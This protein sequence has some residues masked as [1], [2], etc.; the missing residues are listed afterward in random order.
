MDPPKAALG[1]KL[2][3]CALAIRL[4]VGVQRALRTQ[5]VLFENMREVSG[6]HSSSVRDP[7]TMLLKHI[8]MALPAWARHL[9]PFLAVLSAT[10]KLDFCM[11]P[12]T[13]S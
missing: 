7:Q 5:Y 8:D 4:D 1:Q 10:D 3:E 12:V 2:N 11:L 9:E 13:F 6:R